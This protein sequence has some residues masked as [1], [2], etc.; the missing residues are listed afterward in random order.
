MTNNPN[1]DLLHS[2][3]DPNWRTE[4]ELY[5]ALNRQAGFTV[6]LAATADAALVHVNGRPIFLGPGSH[7][8]E[9]GLLCPWYTFIGPGFLNPPFSR[10]LLRQTKNP[11]MDIANWAKKCWEESR[12]GFEVWGVFPFSPQTEW[13]RTYVM[14]H[15]EVS[16]LNT[17]M[18]EIQWSGHAAMQ[19]RRFPHRLSFLRADGSKAQNAGVNSC[20]IVWKD[21]KGMVGPWTPHE[22]YWSH[23]S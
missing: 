3:D 22:F 14:G 20:V 11:A 12:K 19:V 1:M 9:D 10:K 18:L 4:P 6:D 17:G 16:N 15:D 23:R 13:Y 5:Q 2:S 7:I 21:T 8:A